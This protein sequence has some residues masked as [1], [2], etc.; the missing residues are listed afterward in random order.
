[1]LAVGCLAAAAWLG[2]CDL[3]VTDPATLKDSALDDPVLLPSIMNGVRGSFTYA[4]TGPVGGRGVYFA[5]ALL[6]DE[7][8]YSGLDP[9][10]AGF[11][12]GRAQDD[13]DEVNDLWA[14]A[15]RSRWTAENAAGRLDSLIA[16]AAPKDTADVNTMRTDLAEALIWA[17]FSNRMLGENFCQAVIDNGPAQPVSTY[18][19]RAEE[20]FTRAID[21]ATTYNMTDL[22][23][24]A[25]AG[26]AQVRMLAGDWAGATADAALVPTGYNFQ[27]T[28]YYPSDREVNGFRTLSL[29]TRPEFT[30]W[31]TPFADWGRLKGK[32]TGDPRVPYDTPK[33]GGEP[34]IGLDGRR[35]FVQQLKYSVSAAPISVAKGTEM[36]LI[37]AEAALVAGEW[38]TAVAKVQE[39]RDYRN[40]APDKMKLPAA[41]AANADEAWTLLM[42]ER[43]VE[44][45][46]EGRRLGDLRRWAVTPGS[47]PFTVVRESS[48]G[49]AADDVRHNV[50]DVP[51]E[52]CIPVSR[53]EQVT[54]P[55]F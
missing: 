14:E 8:V 41:A 10:L 45:W 4:A 21:L 28:Q 47:V 37:E 36:R 22:L 40:G 33:S 27:T 48:G 1:M 2:A 53:L 43:G 50:L 29:P 19:S 23:T 31:G 12:E 39:V 46:L 44:L 25:I 18:F 42:Q 34:V 17:G 3:N 30:I 32:T 51:G 55:N 35:P 13:W 20:E 24:L 38:E 54:N 52:L 16:R 49:D 6:S 7:A 5:A 11:S 15:S 9:E 26:R